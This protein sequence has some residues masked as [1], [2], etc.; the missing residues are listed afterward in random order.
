MENQNSMSFFHRQKRLP[1]Y[2]CKHCGRQTT[3]VMERSS[4]IVR[5]WF[6]ALY[7]TCQNKGG[8]SLP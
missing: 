6:W 1:L 5:K 3:A 7:M 4:A 8:G 2:T